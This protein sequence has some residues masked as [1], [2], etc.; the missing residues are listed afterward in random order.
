[1]AKRLREWISR[2]RVSILV[3]GV[4]LTVGALAAAVAAVVWWNAQSNRVEGETIPVLVDTTAV[5]GQVSEVSMASPGGG[6]GQGGEERLL[7]R[8]SE[9]REEAQEAVSLPVASGEPLTGEELAPI[10]ARLPALAVEPEDQVDFRLPEDSLPPPRTGETVE[11]PFPPL[12]APV[13]P[14]AVEAGPLEVLRFAPEG[15]I[16]LAPF[17]NVTFNQPMVPL[18]TLGALAAEEVPVQVEPTLPGTWKWL[19]TKTLSFEYESAAID[20]LPMATEYVVTVP[21]GTQSATGGVLAETVRWT[22]ST[23][24]AKMTA[25]YPS[26]EPQPLNPL[27]LVAFDQRVKPEAVLETIQ[28]TADRHAVPV[29]LADDKEIDA[30]KAARRMADGAGD[31]RWL[32]FMAQ[33]PLPADA[34]IQVTIGPGTPSAEGPLVTKEA[35]SYEF[36]TYAPLRIQR[37]GCSWYSD[38]CPPLTPFFIEF[39]N[40]LDADAYEESMLRVEPALPGATVDVVGNTVTIRGSTTGRTIYQVTVSGSIRDTF[41]QTLGEDTRLEFKVGS[42][43]PALIGPDETLVTLDPASKKPIFTVYAIN[44]DHVQV[45]AYQVQPSDWPAFKTYLQAVYQQDKMPEPPGRQV[46]DQTLKLEAAADV[47]AEVSIDLSPAL[48]GGLGQLVVVVEAEG[49]QRVQDRYGRLLQAWV[50]V[51]QI[52]LDAFADHSEMVVWTTA[53]K[54][55]TPLAGV[56]IESLSGKQ[57]AMTGKEGTATFELPGQDTSLLVARQGDDT[58]IL[59]KYPYAWGD[60]A[61]KPRPVQDELRWYVFDDRAMYRPGEDVHVKGWLRRIGGRQDGDVGLPGDALQAV[62]YRVIDPQ[63]NELL[64][65]QAQVNALGGFDLSFTLP[66]NT[67]L[68]YAQ[69]ALRAQGSLGA[70]GGL[71]Y[72]HSFQVQEFLRPEFEVTAR[73][74]TPG[75]YFAGGQATV[76]VEASYYAGGPLPNAEVAWQVSSSPGSYSPPNWPDFAFG[77]WRPWWYAYEPVYFGE[78]YWPYSQQTTIETFSGLTDASG[79]HYLRLDFNQPDAPQPYS[80]LAEATVMDV[81]R[82]AWA[83]A[84]SLLVHPAELYVGLRCDRTF[85]QRGQPLEIEVIVADLDGVAE[86]DRLVEVQAARLEWKYARGAWREEA[87]DVQKC[88]VGSTQEPVS[89]TFETAVGGEYQITA[90][91]TDA[92]GRKNESQFTRWVSGGQRPPSRKVELETA[93]LIPDRESYQPGDVAEI[94]VQS[95]FS[96]AEGLLTVSRS[97]ILYTEPFEIIE[98]TVTLQVPIEEAHIPNLHVQVD[99]V[100]AAPRTDDQGEPVAG[101]PPRPAYASGQLDLSI[102]PLQRTLSLAVTPREVELEPGGETTIDLV[103][104]D[105]DGRP[106]PGAELAV[107]VVDE[108]ILALTNYQLADPVAAFYQ[109]RAADVDSTYGRASIVLASPEALAAE[110]RA[111]TVVETVVVEKEVIVAE[112]LPAAAPEEVAEERPEGQPIRVRADFNPLATFAPEVRTDGNGQAQVAVTLPDNLTRYRVM[113]VAVA[114]GQEFGSAEANLVARL[115]LM[116]RPSAPR[117]LNFGDQFELPVVLQNQTDQPLTIDMILR[118]GNLELTGDAGQRLTVPARDRVE[119]RFPV[120]TINPGTARFQVAAVSGAFADAATVELPVYVPAT[121]EAFA[122]Y[123]VVDEGAVAQP[124]APPGDAVYPQFGGLEI[125]TSSTALQALT[126]AV[127]YLVSYRYECSEQLAS[128]ILAVAALRDVLEAFS[129]EGLPSPADMEAAV[130]RDIE[131][132]QALQNDDGGFPYWSR[133]RESIPFNTIHVAHALQRAENMDF[134]VPPDMKSQVLE[135]LRNIEGYYPA[136]YDKD[137]R[138]TLSAYALYVRNLMGDGDVA[139]VRRLLNDAGLENL[140]LEAVAWL[141]QVLDGDLGSSADVEAIRRHIGNRAVET[142]GAANFTT[143]YSD[144]TYLLLDSD[145]RTDA[146]ILDAMIAGDPASDLIPKVVNGL[147]AHRTEGRW[148]NTQENVFVL[149]ALNRYFGTFEAQTPDFVARIWLGDTYVGAHAYKGRTTERHETAIPMGYLAT[150]DEVQDLILSKEGPGRLYYRLGLRYAPTDLALDP[151][152][153]GFVVQRS[154]EGVDDPEDVAPDE[155][156]VW[157]IKAGARVRVRL[158][159]VADNRRYHVALVDPLP[160]GLEIVN[161]ALAVSGDLPQDPNSPDY[162]YGWWWWGTWYEH[163]NMRDERAEA[164]ASLLW[165]GVYQ[166]S[167]VARATTPGTFVVPPAKVEEMYSPEVFGRSSSDWVIVE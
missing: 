33:E 147:L 42:A 109:T 2:H 84:T 106:V 97:G 138:Q 124:V 32:A 150:S 79:N 5:G 21:A 156:G 10:L 165:E 76:A 64:G 152:D 54:D 13:T 24:P 131:R 123:G 160:A 74:E 48:K 9:G 164:F 99:L 25:Y 56:T 80:V 129:A 49:A 1:M 83:A 163:Q 113:V 70:L 41:G 37:H 3:A 86:P 133:G 14:E 22:F 8:L 155:D 88:T 159:I 68:G 81:N 78:G 118:A 65:G 31:G 98:D 107:V 167:Y 104:T 162:R 101:A 66:T 103:L 96:P 19:G 62:S 157:H 110:G 136:W 141:W 28:V 59:P 87:V 6:A 38:Q 126:D 134:L 149:L 29:R 61:W 89:C 35:Q 75:P 85:V 132:L 73:N 148:N 142:A 20:R 39:N 135:Y 50:Q 127:L 145:R 34:S 45:R 11:E 114:G 57:V 7:I 63:G 119:V 95:P 46:M 158:M 17:V 27:F 52:G 120:T 93:T 91:V 130:E 77:K 116:V 151:A 115:P 12:P 18:A 111:A 146:I 166:Y 4:L 154:Y 26:T 60:D 125:S 108:A 100:G 94:L 23:P 143:S 71:E 44:H 140:S 92:F 117:F 102:P 153:M 69:I 51:T 40:P 72:G 82:Q 36:G 16:P 15:E 67:N 47:L 128:R 137:T 122:T 55:G 139:K 90:T 53:L 58:A 112:A 105:A 30:D 43:E 161:P 121:T 144:Q